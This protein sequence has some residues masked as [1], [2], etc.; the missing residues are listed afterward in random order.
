MVMLFSLGRFTSQLDFVVLPNC[1]LGILCILLIHEPRIDAKRATWQAEN[2]I[3]VCA[4]RRCSVV[5]V[6][7]SNGKSAWPPRLQPRRLLT[8]R[9]DGGLPQ[10]ARSFKR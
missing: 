1:G 10:T 3:A 4:V 5:R 6:Q 2:V 9:H 8:F 7:F